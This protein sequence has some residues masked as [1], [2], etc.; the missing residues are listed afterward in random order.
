MATFGQTTDNG[1]TQTFSAD[2]IYV[3]TA[4][5]SSSGTVTAGKGRIWLSGVAFGFC[6]I[7]IYSHIPGLGPTNLLATSDEV[8]FTHTTEQEVTFPFS[9]ANQISVVG[10]TQYWFGYMFDDPGTPSMVMS[11]ANN[12]GV[13]HFDAVVYPNAPATFTSDGTAPGPHD[14]YIEYTESTGTIKKT[15]YQ[16]SQ[17]INRSSTY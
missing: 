2:R 6:R 10:G 4:T 17:A 5:P 9:G 12:A 11:R 3:S 15:I 8:S 14:C 1:N 16:V 7:V 13:V